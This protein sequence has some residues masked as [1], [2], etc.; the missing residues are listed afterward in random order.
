MVRSR[1]TMSAPAPAA[2]ANAAIPPAVTTAVTRTVAARRTGGSSSSGTRSG[3]EAGEDV[4][5]SGDASCDAPH[6]VPTAYNAR[7]GGLDTGELRCLFVDL[8]EY[9]ARDL[10]A[11]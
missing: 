7:G 1:G 11:S 5:R 4:L 8:F 3:A 10:L 6:A 2:G 9:Q